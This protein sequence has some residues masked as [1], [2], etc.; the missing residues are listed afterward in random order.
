MG[1]KKMIDI[2]EGAIK[3]H[4]LVPFG[5]DVTKKDIDKLVKKHL[6]FKKLKEQQDAI[7]E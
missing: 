6:K 1:K 7:S 3:T 5:R 2:S 4:N